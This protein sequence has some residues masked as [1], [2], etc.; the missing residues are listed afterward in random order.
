MK[1]LYNTTNYELTIKEALNINDN[2][3]K[4]VIF[5]CYWNGPLTEKH[6]YSIKSC[7]YFNI[8]KKPS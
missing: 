7:Y 3:N 1:L 6:Y 8:F 2:Y 4:S 5:H